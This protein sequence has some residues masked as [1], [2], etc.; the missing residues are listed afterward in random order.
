MKEIHLPIAKKKK[1]LRLPKV[2]DS[3]SNK[4]ILLPKDMLISVLRL[5]VKYINLVF[6]GSKW[7]EIIDLKSRHLLLKSLDTVGTD[8]C[9]DFNI[10]FQ[11]RK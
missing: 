10:S 8:V 6:R 2:Q 5:E 9:V 1:I 11:D 3:F 4:K 7:R